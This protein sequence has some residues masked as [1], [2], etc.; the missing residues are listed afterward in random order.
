MVVALKLRASTARA[1]IGATA[2]LVA[3]ALAQPA[4]AQTS[5]AQ[6]DPAKKPATETRKPATGQFPYPGDSAPAPTTPSTQNPS[7]TPDAPAPSAK[8]KFFPYPGEASPSTAT[9]PDNPTPTGDSS[10]SSSSSGSSSSPGSS[11]DPDMPEPTP[12][13]TAKAV[14]RRKLPKVQNLQSDDDRE[15]EDL[16]VARFYRDRGNLNAAYLR[17]KDAVKHQPDDPD[18]HLLLA[19]LAQKL[20]KHDEA[21]SEYNALLKLD[22]SEEQVKTAHKALARLQ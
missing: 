13:D 21:V 6:P 11:A 4:Q 12:S 22:A 8:P 15:A 9:P 17:S 1:A 14:P 20:N 5:P 7:A 3:S 2:L 18:A 10:S 16:T 19:E